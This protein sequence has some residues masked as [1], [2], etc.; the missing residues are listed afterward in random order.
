MCRII[1]DI[2][3]RELG[4][5]RKESQIETAYRMIEYGSFSAEIIAVISGL[6]LNE[7]EQLISNRFA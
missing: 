6:P 7:V 3:E 2:V 4:R 1:E 5:V